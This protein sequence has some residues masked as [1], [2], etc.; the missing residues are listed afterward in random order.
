VA[1]QESQLG[2]FF[3]TIITATCTG[4]TQAGMVVGFRAQERA[5]RVIG[6]DTAANPEMTRRAVTKIARAPPEPVGLER[7][8]R[9]R[10]VIVEPCGGGRAY[11]V[12]RQEAIA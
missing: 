4:S 10:D 2:V 5:R 6:I 3:D 12:A 11:G 8:I 1:Q 9:D 7:E